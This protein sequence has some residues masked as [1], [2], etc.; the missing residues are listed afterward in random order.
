[1]VA[2]AHPAASRI[3]LEALQS[4]GTA[5]DAAVAAQ[6]AL[7]LVEPQSSGIGGGAFLVYYSAKDHRLTT[8]DG[9]ETAPAGIRPDVFLD[10]TTGR[11]KMLLD[12]IVGGSSVGV[13]GVLR[14]LE[15]AQKRHGSLPWERLFAPAIKLAQQ[16]FVVSPRLARQLAEDKFLKN[17]PTAAAY[18]YHPDGSPRQAGEILVNLPL[19]DTLSRVAQGGA[20]AFYH[21]DIADAVAAAVQHATSNPG[22]MTPADLAAYQAVERPA[23][24]LRYRVFTVCG[25][26]PPTSGGVATLQILGMLSHFDMSRYGSET[27]DA[28]QLMTEASRLAFAD[29]EKFLAD[30]DFVSVPVAG[31]LDPGYLEQRAA[32]IHPDSSIG[33]AVAGNPPGGGHS[34][35]AAGDAA[36]LSATS[37]IAIIDSDGNVASMTTSV[38]AVF[39][40]RQMVRGFILNN[41]LTDFSFVPQV[42]GIAVA[43]RVEPRKRPRSSMSPT[44]VFDEQGQV[45]AAVGSAGGSHIIGYV[46]KTLIAMLDWH[47]DPQRASNLP[48]VTNLNG[49]TELEADTPLV[50]LLPALE[51]RGDVVKITPLESGL[52][53]IGIVASLG[54]LVGGVDRRREGLVLGGP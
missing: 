10:P 37:H 35:G 18:F 33:M 36:E 29:R 47:Q 2:T 9:R 11:P 4:G 17:N 30:P 25:M 22:S 21:G 44:I 14:M 8:F 12:A 34:G 24:C 51:S 31:L 53:G 45:L 39:G 20:D 41:E 6:A 32:L 1:M 48:N 13:P 5:V 27:A 15:L 26:G 38:E 52:D 28:V 3:A 7:T 43:N 54:L 40:S 16:G 49:P 50:A 23:I 19:A 46:L 42:N